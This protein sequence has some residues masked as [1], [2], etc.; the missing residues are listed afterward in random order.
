MFGIDAKI[1]ELYVGDASGDMVGLI[2]GKVVQSSGKCGTKDCCANKQK[3]QKDK[4]TMIDSQW[5]SVLGLHCE[6]GFRH[7]TRGGVKG[8]NRDSKIGSILALTI[9]MHRESAAS[10]V[11]ASSSTT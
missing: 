2:E 8:S 4:G 10:V 3:K 5:L 1:A 7:K 11:S 9:P 6:A